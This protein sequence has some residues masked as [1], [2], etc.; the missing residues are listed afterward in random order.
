VAAAVGGSRI[1]LRVHWWSDVV[2][3]WAVGAAIFGAVA[4]I[5]VV[6]DYFRNNDE[7]EPAATPAA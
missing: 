5:G 7:S 1:Y 3:G 4:A 2:A 6:V